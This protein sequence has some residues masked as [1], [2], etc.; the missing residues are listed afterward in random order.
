M[1]SPAIPSNFV[2]QQGNGETLLS[3]NITAGA[4]SYQ[5]Q[6]STDG[7]SFSLLA[8][9]VVN[10]Y[11]DTTVTVGT[12]YYYKIA[13]TNSDGTSPYTSAQSIIPARTGDLSLG[14]LRQMSKLRADM[15]NSNFLTTAEWNYNINNSYFELYDLLVT[16]YEDYFLAAPYIFQTTSAAQYDLPNDFYKLVGLDAGL[17]NNNNAWISLPK[18]EFIERNSFIYPQLNST[19]L[20]VG[21]F[22]YR[23]MGNTLYFIP[24]PTAGQYIRAWYIPK[25]TQL[26]ED[27]DIA[28]GVSGWLEYVIVDAAI[29]ALQKEESDVSV[30]MAQKMALI[31]RIEESAMNRDVGLPDRVSDSRSRTNQ[32]NGYPSGYWGGW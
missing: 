14:Q 29:K 17:S 22:R 13:A 16:V 5:V 32:L 27:T 6:R 8:S 2:L 1:A 4:T 20:G 15:A 21:N 25:L 28:T 3:W 9:P 18:F 23:L 11:L 26:L 31:K 10:S 7:V 19:L 24:T 30:L 12:L